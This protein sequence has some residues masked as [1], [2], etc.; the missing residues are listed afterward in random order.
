MVVCPY[1]YTHH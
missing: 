1:Q